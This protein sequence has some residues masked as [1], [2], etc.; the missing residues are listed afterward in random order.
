MDENDVSLDRE[1]WEGE[2]MFQRKADISLI[3][4]RYYRM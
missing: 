4:K 3:N 1:L 2:L